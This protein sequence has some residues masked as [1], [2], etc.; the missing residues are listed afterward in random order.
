[1]HSPITQTAPLQQVWLAAS[2]VLSRPFRLGLDL[3]DPKPE[4]LGRLSE[5]WSFTH[6]LLFML[7]NKSLNSNS[8]RRCTRDL[9]QVRRKEETAQGI[10][11]VSQPG[12]R[13]A[14]RNSWI[15]R[16]PDTTPSLRAAPT[17]PQ[18]PRPLPRSILPSDVSP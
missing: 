9:L 14:R 1:M 6:C 18:P 8:S 10:L 13:P 7:W 3:K 12:L 11:G 16:H 2:K 17:T 4:K 5:T 15:Q